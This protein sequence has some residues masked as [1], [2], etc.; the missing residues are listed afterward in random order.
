MLGRIAF[1]DAPP[2][3]RLAVAD[4][5]VVTYIPGRRF[6]WAF[7]KEAENPVAG[8]AATL[9]Y[10]FAVHALGRDEA[11]KCDRSRMTA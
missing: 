5:R 11:E 7:Q 2:E 3:A 9:P 8:A 4:H 1:R 10:A 6:D